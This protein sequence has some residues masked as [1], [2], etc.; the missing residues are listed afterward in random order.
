M[1]AKVQ[2][3]DIQKAE[4]NGS[5]FLNTYD[6]NKSK[7]EEEKLQEQQ[8]QSMLD[9]QTEQEEKA[10]SKRNSQKANM[11]MLSANEALKNGKAKTMFKGNLSFD[12]V[13]A[14]L[15]LP[16]EVQQQAQRFI[17]NPAELEKVLKNFDITKKY[18]ITGADQKAVEAILNK[19]EKDPVGALKLFG[20][21][22]DVQSNKINQQTIM[23]LLEEAFQ[24]LAKSLIATAKDNNEIG[25][26]DQDQQND[27]IKYLQAILADTQKAYDKAIRKAK[28]AH[29]WD[30]FKKVVGAIV[31][32]ALIITGAVL[33]ATGVGAGLGAAL[34]VGGIATIISCDFS[35]MIMKAINTYATNSSDSA[36]SR[37][38]KKIALKSLFAVIMATLS[39]IA[40]VTSGG[41]AIVSTVA[42]IGA[43]V[44]TF[45]SVGGADDCIELHDDY[46]YD[47]DMEQGGYELHSSEVKKQEKIAQIITLTVA[48]LCAVVSI[49]SLA[50][51][52]ISAVN[53]ARA[54]KNLG[55]EIEMTTIN[56][57]STTQEEVSESIEETQVM[58]AEENTS[59]PTGKDANKTLETRENGLLD[60]FR[61]IQ[62][63]FKQ[64]S[65]A[66]IQA[67]KTGSTIFQTTANGGQIALTT[68]Q[69]ILLEQEA[70]A[71]LN[72]S[73]LNSN[74]SRS[75]RSL[76][77]GTQMIK[78]D[79]TAKEAQTVQVITT[80][81]TDANI[82][83][84]A[85]Q[86]Q[87]RIISEVAV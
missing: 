67:L 63:A 61:K 33:C 84:E 7:L 28:K 45:T 73:M 40:V 35:D 44:G 17:Q 46:A 6:K 12:K 76:D 64:I 47:C 38:W 79:D 29:F 55:Q 59:G 15:K 14:A 65:P 43:L 60:T 77:V 5:Y 87:A 34:I 51:S 1:D 85:M 54:A 72:A 18:S 86:Q 82:E 22:I 10:F 37:E 27:H 71:L 20:I 83:Q 19:V 74:F 24:S 21:N 57:L 16:K 49:G 39:L 41:T 11:R 4:P 75:E 36:A 66:K 70:Q 13:F 69:G 26:L 81:Q 50:S 8:E 9:A 31:G 32:A 56:D 62:T 48:A 52:A 23:Q 25:S 68:T 78:Q 42:T 80:E 2:P 3:K 53:A 58:D 30:V